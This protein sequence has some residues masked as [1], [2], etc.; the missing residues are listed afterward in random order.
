MRTYLSPPL[1]TTQNLLTAISSFLSPPHVA[2]DILLDRGDEL[3]RGGDEPY[4]RGKISSFQ[5]K[6]AR[7]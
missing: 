1:T 7:V 2:R 6:E 4:P 3:D 5:T